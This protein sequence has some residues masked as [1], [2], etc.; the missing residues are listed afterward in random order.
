MA[1][2]M[3]GGS[4]VVRSAGKVEVLV[5][6]VGAGGVIEREEE[7]RRYGRARLYCLMFL[8]LPPWPGIKART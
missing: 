8:N 7:R 6:V 2:E 4:K 1:L 5:L 3:A